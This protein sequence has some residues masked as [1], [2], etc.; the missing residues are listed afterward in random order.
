MNELRGSTEKQGRN[1]S[2]KTVIVAVA[3]SAGIVGAFLVFSSPTRGVLRIGGAMALQSFRDML[4]PAASA[5]V[6]SDVPFLPMDPASDTA[7]ASEG[8][9]SSAPSPSSTSSVFP[10]SL[11]IVKQRSSAPVLAAPLSPPRGIAAIPPSPPEDPSLLETGG[12]SFSRENS[13]PIPSSSAGNPVAGQVVIPVAPPS[14]CSFSD[15]DASAVLRDV[16]IN[17]IAWMGSPAETGET[18]ERAAGREWMELKN[19]S[20]GAIDLAGWRVVDAAGKIVISF[21]SG[22]MI[23]AHGLYLLSRN[24]IAVHGILPDKAYTGALANTGDG[25]A[26]FD[27]SCRVEDVATA[28]SSW[29]GGSNTT[30]QTLERRADF[31]WQ[32]SFMP[33]GTPRTENSS[34]VPVFV[35][36]ST[37]TLPVYNLDIM[38]GGDGNG[39]VAIQP[40]GVVCTSSVVRP[41][42]FGTKLTLSATS[43]AGTDFLGWSG[44]CSGK[45]KCDF[46]V[47]GATS[48]TAEF[49]LKKDLSLP[50][51]VS[52]ATGA[53]MTKTESTTQE[54]SSDVM[55]ASAGEGTSSA[56][57][58]SV[59]P[60]LLI[61]A[62]QI[63]GT[64]ANDDFVK[65]YNPMPNPIDV[66]GWKLRKKTS[67]GGD[68]SVRE[69]P[70]GSMV[71]GGSYFTWMSVAG[72]FAGSVGA[73][74]SSTA[75]LA[76][77]NSV[78]LFDATGTEVDAVAWGVGTDPY[79]EG[80]PYPDNPPEGQELARR[81]SGGTAIDTDNNADD[82][83]IIPTPSL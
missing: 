6:I 34:G 13:T 38:I 14:D 74:V 59:S 39:K 18:A 61:S 19:V 5:P 33:G 63:A 49:R 58:F 41:Y 75:T 48:V 40:G 4:A 12:F 23:P 72:D 29:P 83:S 27:A 80:A 24:G 69:F 1:I 30:K 16:I 65:I 67:T 78:A 17:E 57:I 79:V 3:I 52:V 25:M 56:P 10:D 35:A 46:I 7:G 68:S 73:D 32:T 70:N 26:V 2:R 43:L 64:S 77:N 15:A 45:N 51:L 28:S 62:V 36:V 71:E 9:S 11:H 76:A 21:G 66:G 37:D 54:A 47:S 22:D 55:D 81:F 31:G 8:T 50:A 82:F 44:V 60:H 20:S 42:P 53:S